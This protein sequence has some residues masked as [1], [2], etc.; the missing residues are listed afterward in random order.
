MNNKELD[1][2]KSGK[3]KEQIKVIDYFTK[4]GCCASFGLMKDAEY[5]KMVRDKRDALKL[6]E[7]AL[8]KI[9][10]DESQVNEIAPV[11]LQGYRFDRAFAKKS[12]AGRW[13]SSSYEVAWLFFSSTQVY[14]Y[15][16]RF[17]MDEDKKTESTQEFFYKDITAFST[18]TTNYSSSDDEGKNKVKVVGDQKVEVETTQF[19]ITVPGEKLVVAMDADEVPD[20]EAIVQGMKQKLREK[21]Q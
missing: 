2:F 5:S 17:N 10:L 14:L 20:H 9:G 18:A 7:K 6:R 12:A 1:Q 8:S 15:S 19:Q 11:C 13:V 16:M 4:S 3:T 21:K